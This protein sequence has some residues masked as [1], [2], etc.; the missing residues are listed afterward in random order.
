MKQPQT[1]KALEDVGRVRLSR[2]FFMRDF[3]YSEISAMSKIPNIPDDPDL[4]IAAG[5]KLCE[6]LLEPL[7]VTF[8]GLTI[9]SAYR[10]C[11]VNGY[12]NEHG[13]NCASNEA[14]FAAHR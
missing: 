10:S 8:G 4:A 12:G 14:N 2:H 7:H 13:L 6:E 11:S 9:R 3:L 5:S 1:I